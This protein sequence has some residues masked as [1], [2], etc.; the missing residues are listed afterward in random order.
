M[1][2]ALEPRLERRLTRAL[3]AGRLLMLWEQGVQVWAP[4]VLA[5]LAVATAGLW[6]AFDALPLPLHLGL[7]G[8]AFAV[9]AGFSVR[10]ALKLRWPA[11]AEARA[12]LEADSRLEHA[13]LSALEDTQAA[14]DP[15]LWV[16]HHARAAEAIAHARV[17]PARAVLSAADPLAIRWALVLAAVLALWARGPERVPYAAQAFRP[18][19]DLARL[20][21]R[22]D[23]GPTLARAYPQPLWIRTATAPSVWPPSPS[24]PT[25]REPAT[26]SSR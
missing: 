4:L 6:G 9:A 26:D 23:V 19:G 1:P 5:A 3:W 22:R 7:L 11:R 17:G 2:P 13:P 10:G 12:R 20:A 25:R 21:T 8:L 18:V 15:A 14:G 16:L 24:L